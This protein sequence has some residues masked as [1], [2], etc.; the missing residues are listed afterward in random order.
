MG[1]LGWIGDQD[2]RNCRRGGGAAPPN[3]YR[4]AW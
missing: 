3:R 2:R 1:A 4:E